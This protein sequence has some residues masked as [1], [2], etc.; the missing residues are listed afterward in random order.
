MDSKICV[1]CNIEKSIDNFYNKYRE[2][3]PCNNNRSTKR[4]N[5]NEDKIS[6]QHKLYYEKNRDV[7]LAKSK[8]N[9][10]KR[11][12]ERKISKQ[13]VQ[14]LNQKLQDLTQAFEMLK[15]K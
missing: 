12:Y 2:C 8:V 14:E 1:V 5:E 10:Q 9:Q 6:D 15:T 7:L 4:Y 13:Q 3:K 11:N